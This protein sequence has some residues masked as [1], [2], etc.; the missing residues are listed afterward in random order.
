MK[1]KIYIIPNH[2]R[3]QPTHCSS[4]DQ[5]YLRCKLRNVPYTSQQS[6]SQEQEEEACKIVRCCKWSGSSSQFHYYRIR[7]TS[8]ATH[9]MPIL[10]HVAKDVVL[11]GGRISSSTST[12]HQGGAGKKSTT[13]KDSPHRL[14]GDLRCMYCF[15]ANRYFMAPL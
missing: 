4:L 11:S 9:F 15:V 10:H 5:P 1:W 2:H 7:K 13:K 6:L 8:T 14:R 3:K 12:K